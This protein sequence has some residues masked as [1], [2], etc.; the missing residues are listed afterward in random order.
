MQLTCITT[1]TSA[2]TDSAEETV[3]DSGLKENLHK[4][5]AYV[6]IVS[7]CFDINDA[8]HFYH[9]ILPASPTGERLTFNLK[10]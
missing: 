7:G 4:L 3:G 1:H 5:K 2:L 8:I 10:L 6:A 9:F